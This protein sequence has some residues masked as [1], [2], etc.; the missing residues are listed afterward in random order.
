M[1]RLT[2]ADVEHVA[3][4][5]RLALT[6][7]EIEHF[8]A[9]LEVIL[10]HA[11][12]VAALDTHDVPPTAHPLPA[13]QR[14]A[15]RRGAAEPAARRSAGHGAGGGRRPVPRP[16]HPRRT[17]SAVTALELAAAVRGGTAPRVRSST[18]TSR[19]SPPATAS[20]TPATS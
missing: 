3:L 8:T 14:A 4:L 17:V 13:R 1:S 15:R 16:A 20:S 7:D 11:A 12:Q 5:A 6:D 18:S 2:R 9:Q 10:E 19:S